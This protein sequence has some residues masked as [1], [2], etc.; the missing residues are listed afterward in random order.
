MRL[1]NWNC[2][3]LG[4]PCTVLE[5]LLLIKEQDPFILFLSETILD[6][7]G[8]EWLRVKIKFLGAF[9]VPHMGNGGGLAML[10]NDKVNV[11]LNTFSKNHIDVSVTDKVGGKNFRVT[12]FYGNAETHT[13]KES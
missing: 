11:E 13:T 6:S 7:V 3:G 8:V 5:L 2:R 4:N 1:L 9:Y 12:G 10:W